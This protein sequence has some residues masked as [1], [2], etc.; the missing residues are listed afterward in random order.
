VK[1]PRGAPERRGKPGKRDARW[2]VVEVFP[3][4]QGEESDLVKNMT[5]LRMAAALAVATAVL[6]GCAP[7][8]YER[9]DDSYYGE[10]RDAVY[11]PPPASTSVW[12]NAAPPIGEPA[13]VLVPYGP[14][15]MPMEVMPPRPYVDMMWV[16]G[17]WYWRGGWVWTRGRWT[18]PPQPNYEWVR[19]HYERHDSGVSFVPGHWGSGNRFVPRETPRQPPQP[20]PW[21][22]DDDRRQN[23]R[24][25]RQPWS[26]RQ[27]QPPVPVPVPQGRFGQP[28]P[29]YGG[30][31]Q[32]RFQPFPQG[33][34]PRTVQ[35]VP[36]DR[37][38][39]VG[40]DGTVPRYSNQNQWR[41]NRWADQPAREQPGRGEV[42]GREAQQ[43]ARPPAVVVPQP[44]PRPDPGVARPREER[45][46]QRPREEQREQRDQR[47]F[48]R[49]FGRRDEQDNA[50]DR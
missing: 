49:G 18:R 22:R 4:R 26:N 50:R 36:T 33:Q 23:E 14:P 17:S 15:P 25:E 47:R 11:A 39:A 12:I 44:Q 20:A 41:A 43:P 7:Y 31:P 38:D 34:D 30:Q 32:P 1:S 35:P 42:Q 3:C 9:Y 37:R 2:C 40:R 5:R 21:G 10:D 19:P 16:P 48:M 13:P 6:G 27:E 28:Q 8:P 45:Q 46:E 29:A 24:R